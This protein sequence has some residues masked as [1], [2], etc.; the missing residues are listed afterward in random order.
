MLTVHPFPLWFVP[1][2]VLC[3]SIAIR[4]RRHFF[5][6]RVALKT[7]SFVRIV[8][9]LPGEE[10]RCMLI[11]GDSS[12][13]QYRIALRDGTVLTYGREEFEEWADSREKDQTLTD[14][15]RRGA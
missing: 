1:F 13:N 5:P 4:I 7:P 12:A 11:R 8:N 15:S 3:S 14:I 6:S 9:P 2:I 10:G